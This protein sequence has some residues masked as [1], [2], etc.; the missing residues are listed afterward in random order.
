MNKE[1]FKPYKP[2]NP[3]DKTNSIIE[4]V[5][6][7]FKD[8]Y[9]IYQNMSNLII[10]EIPNNAGSKVKLYFRVS[11]LPGFSYNDNG[12]YNIQC[13]L[14]RNA[15]NGVSA[16][17]KEGYIDTISSVVKNIE[18]QLLKYTEFIKGYSEYIEDN[19]LWIHSINLNDI[20]LYIKNRISNETVVLEPALTIG[21][22]NMCAT[23]KLNNIK[24]NYPM[25]VYSSI[26]F[27]D[28]DGFVE[29]L[30]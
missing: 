14:D 8:K 29:I 16:D 24:G 28:L 27:E 17:V 18:Y 2:I 26:S 30:S 12:I 19:P 21:D 25:T 10:L 7:H 15:F 4:E 22:G 9:T 3:E 23:M 11:G 6:N 20:K 1:M 5:I 13:T